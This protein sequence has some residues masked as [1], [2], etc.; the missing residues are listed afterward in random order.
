MGAQVRAASVFGS[1]DD[2][3]RYFPSPRG[4]SEQDFEHDIFGSVRFL[5]HAQAALFVPLIENRRVTNTLTEAGG[6]VGDV[7]LSAR[8]DFFEA[9][10]S[11]YMPGIAALAGVTFPTGVSPESASRPLAT[12]S[13]GTGAFQ[14]N[15]GLALEQSRGRWLFNITCLLAKRATHS[16]Q[17]V[18]STLGT[19]ITLLAAT[20]YVFDNDAALALVA[21]YAA[22]GDAKVNGLT[23]TGSSRRT[24]ILSVSGVWPITDRLR[25]QGSIFLNPPILDLGTNEPTSTGF[26]FGVVHSWS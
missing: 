14:G 6:G 13:T 5:K 1:W 4:A 18:D 3:G 19:R 16:V 8:Y 17:G 25:L 23:A 12:D 15:M 24:T 7:N 2:T 22:E 10:Q 21:S 11:R 9:G 26:T 20:G